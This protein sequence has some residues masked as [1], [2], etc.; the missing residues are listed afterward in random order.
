MD[1]DIG[2]ALTAPGLSLDPIKWP[3]RLKEPNQGERRSS[4]LALNR[5]TI[6]IVC[7]PCFPGAIDTS[8]LCSLLLCLLIFLVHFEYPFK[9]AREVL[10]DIVSSSADISIL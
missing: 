1:S 8:L 10:R 5:K 3:I 4:I 9:C 2:A 6:A 7:L